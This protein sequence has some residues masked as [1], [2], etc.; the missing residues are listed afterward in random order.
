VKIFP[1]YEKNRNFMT[2]NLD[3]EIFIFK[4]DLRLKWGQYYP[5]FCL[6]LLSQVKNLV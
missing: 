6:R 5:H 3:L 1:L 4:S 2:L